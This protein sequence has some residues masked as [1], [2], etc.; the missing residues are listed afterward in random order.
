MK[1]FGKDK[2]IT[3]FKLNIY[4]LDFVS[5]NENSFGLITYLYGSLKNHSIVSSTYCNEWGEF[6]KR[7]H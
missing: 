6:E 4:V 2:H 7:A 1:I 3:L 5:K